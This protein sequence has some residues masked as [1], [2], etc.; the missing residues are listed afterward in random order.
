[1]LP[2]LLHWQLG[3][4]TGTELLPAPAAF[5]KAPAAL[6][7]RRIHQHNIIERLLQSNLVQQWDLN[8]NQA[9]PTPDQLLNAVTQALQH[10]RMQQ[11]LHKL[12]VL[13]MAHRR[14]EDALRQELGPHPVVGVEQLC[15]EALS[16]LL[17]DLRVGCKQLVHDGV[18]L[19][20]W[21]A[22]LPE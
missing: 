13:P 15:A 6:G 9:L 12:P 3:S 8:H 11:L 17:P 21:N 10:L 14:T 5:S 1:L 22:L 18:R 7:K 2:L 19:Q 20:H 16:E 4:H